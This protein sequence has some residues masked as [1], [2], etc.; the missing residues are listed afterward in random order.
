MAKKID[1]NGLDHFKE[2]ENAMIASEY[3]SSKTYAVGDYCYHAGTLYCCT[4]AITTAENWTSGHWTAAK[5]ADDTSALKTAITQLEDVVVVS[6]VE[7]TSE[8]NKIW[9]NSE[10]DSVQIPTVDDL[11]VV[12]A[13]AFP[14]ETL[15]NQSIATFDDGADK[16]PVKSITVGVTTPQYGSGDPN[17]T[18]NIR[19]FSEWDGVNVSVTGVNVWD[20]DWELGGLVYADG[21]K[22]DTSDRIR[23]K[24]FCPC[25]PNTQYFMKSLNDQIT[26]QI[27]YYAKDKSYIS[28]NGY[29]DSVFTTVNNAYYFKVVISTITTYTSGVSVNYPSTDTLYHPYNP[30]S[31]TYFIEFPSGDAI[32]GGTYDISNGSFTAI[33]TKYI[34]QSA[35]AT[36]QAGKP[37]IFTITTAL[38]P[39][40][41]A[42]SS[43]VSTM[44]NRDYKCSHYKKNGIQSGSASVTDMDDLSC[45]VYGNVIN[46][47]DESISIEQFNT[48]AQAQYANGTPITI[49]YKRAE[50][51]IIQL[52]EVAIKTVLGNNNLWADT[53]DVKN[54][55]YRADVG[56]YINKVISNS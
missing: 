50:P 54:L 2:K 51:Q 11:S 23:S 48:Y 16:I 8:Y 18:D 7:P 10:S 44:R 45:Y 41:E 42:F 3:S 4:T 27:F 15:T 35:S 5:L 53:G 22:F 21:S 36:W 20:E 55:V 40:A 34:V 37:H 19:P 39:Q 32:V 12:V 26:V 25:L 49:I 47:R 17:P 1:L 31:K 28:Y 56:M 30:D 38:T 43:S 6:N 29:K 46:I 14:T 52:D 13:S 33:Y 24:N 9:V